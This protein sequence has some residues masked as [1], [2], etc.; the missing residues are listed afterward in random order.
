MGLYKEDGKGGRDGAETARKFYKRF[1]LP[2]LVGK[3]ATIV[4]YSHCKKTC[5][6]FWKQLCQ[7]DYSHYKFELNT[8]APRN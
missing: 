8:T 4:F 3:V 6:L 5:K 1:F 7:L 2:C